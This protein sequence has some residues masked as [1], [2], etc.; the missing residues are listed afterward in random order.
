MFSKFSEEA[1]QILVLAKK[2]MNKLKH[3]YVGSEHLLLALLSQED[4]E[5]TERLKKY[6]ITYQNFKQELIKAVGI[7]TSANTWFLYTPLLKRIIEATMLESRENKEKE[8][9]VEQLF[10]SLLEEGEG[11]AIRILMG[12]N[13]DID[14]LY[15]EFSKKMIHKKAKSKKKL[16][17]EE[18]A[19]N[20]NKKVSSGEFDPVI[21]REE[22]VNRLIEILCRRTKNNPLLIG[23][24][25]VGKTAIV[26]ELVRKI[27]QKKVP[28]TLK[29]KRVFSIAMATLVAGTKYRG[30]FEERMNQIL[31]EIENS[32]DIIIFVDEIHTLIGAGGADGAIDASNILKPAL[33]RG[34]IRLIGATTTDEYAEFMEHDKALDRRFQRVMVEEV[35]NTKTKKILKGLVPIYESFHGTVIKDEYLDLII[36]LTNK[37]MSDRKQPDKAID[38]LDEACVKASLEKTTLDK[39]GEEL[40]DK[41]IEVK[42]K[43]N[44]VIIIQDFETASKLKNIERELESKLNKLMLKK[45]DEIKPKEIT[46]KMIADIVYLKTKIPI[47]EVSNNY[48][49]KILN[50]EKKLNEKIIGQE[51]AVKVISN[52]TKRLK[53]G[54]SPDKPHS[55]LLVGDTGI[56]KTLLVKEYAKMI[57]DKD[58]FLRLDMSEYKEDH[59]ISKIIGSPPGYVGYKDNN[60]LTDLVKFQPHSII[61]LDEIE[62]ASPKVLK[63][64]LQVLDDGKI[65]NSKGVVINFSNTTIFMTS[66]IGMD[67]ESIGYEQ[68]KAKK[69]E[70]ELIDSFGREFINRVDDIVN[71]KKLDS[72]SIQKIIKTKLQELKE[73][74]LER[75]VTIQFDQKLNQLILEKSKY[76]EYGARKIDKIMNNFIEEYIIDGLL[77]DKKEIDLRRLNVL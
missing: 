26:E 46:K 24:A 47:Y 25:G 60:S 14:A 36:K 7:G 68:I 6:K 49:A 22:E 27:V 50:L 45:M 29:N 35:N 73:K 63:L 5:V 42:D 17:L 34:K 4:L 11:V 72:K 30:E 1:Q 51:E 59:T 21:E 66:N 53:L 70:R 20:L 32:E 48:D 16:L 23:D 43:K 2:E 41:L 74:Y 12:M 28:D 18:L 10:L 52:Y 39:K 19:V 69:Q 40:R 44:Q 61:L 58:H 65:K 77:E 57:L 56:G 15:H 64:F 13:I 76:K 54:F 75:G 8:I 62:K 37:Y 31:L 67:K 55:F 33:A 38:I 71:M 3:P 9:N